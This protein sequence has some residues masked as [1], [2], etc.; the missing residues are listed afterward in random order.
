MALL[1]QPELEASVVH[2]Y[3]EDPDHILSW[4]AFR[5]TDSHGKI[6][7]G[8]M[9][10]PKNSCE[11]V[12]EWLT[13]FYS[14]EKEYTIE[15]SGA[16]QD[17]WYDLFFKFAPDVIIAMRQD[18]S[19]H[20]KRYYRFSKFSGGALL[21]ISKQE[22]SA[23]A[24]YLQKRAAVVFDLAYRRFSDLQ[25]TEAQARE[26]QIETALERVRSSSLA[27]H[28]S[29]ELKDVVK[30]VFENFRSLGLQNIDSV[31]IN[32]FHE[33]SRDFDLWLAAPGQDYTTNF[34][35][36][37]LDHPIANDFFNDVKKGETIHKG[38]YDHDL[39]NKYFEYMFENSDN[40][41]LPEERKK[42]ILNGRAY[43]VATGIAKHSSIFIHNYNGEKFSEETNGI[44]VRFSKV[45]DQAYTR[46]L[47]LQKAE[48][49]ARE[50]QI[51]TVLER[52]RSRTMA[53]QKSN[54]LTDVA[55]LL[56]EQVSALG[57]KTWTAGFNVWSEDN[58]SYVDYIT[59]PQG[60]F[61][62]PY[63][64]YTDTAEALTDISN[65]RK[66]GVEFDVQYVE[67][68]KIKQLYLALTKLDEKQ[69]EI[70]LQDGIRFPSHQYEHFVFGSKV[71]LMFIT[72]EPVP[73]AHDIFK[74]LGKVFEQTYTRFLDLQKAEANA[75]EA[76][77]EA[78]LERVRAKAMAMHSSKDLAET[79]SVFYRELKSLSV[80]PIRCGVALMDKESRMA[81]LTTM[82]T[83]GEGDSIEI[84]GKIKMAGHPVLDGVFESWLV[85]KEYHAVLRG[86]Q[87]KEYYQVLKPQIDYLDYSHDE[88]QFGYYFMFKEGDVYAWTEKE[89]T[90]DEL[91]IYR[92]FTTVISLTYKRYKD[93]Q[94]AEA[95]AREAKI[96]AGLER[97]RAR[98]M[99]MHSSEDVGAATAT[100]FTE[101]EKLGIQNLRGGITVI[102]A[103]DKQEVWGVTNLP[104]GRIIRS[105]GEFDMHLHALWRELLKAKLNNGDYNYYRLAGKDKEDY[106][107]ILNATPNYLSQPIK[108]FPDVHVQSYFF[109]EG[110]IWTNSLQPHSE[111][112]K[113]VMK[114]FAS[115]F[116]LT[117]RRYQDLQKA[118]AQAREAT[119]EACI[120]KSSW[121]SNGYAQFKRSCLYDRDYSI[122]NWRV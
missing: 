59:S 94:Q 114:R 33:G 27:M 61:I 105:I 35:L 31:N 90:E 1:G 100:M 112:D 87:I 70:M 117:F 16:K 12:R 54:E 58:N 63:T 103:G 88:A 119:I 50:A 73:E 38:I 23:E 49:Q 19:I 57:I 30:I 69:Y 39:K 43:S 74:R 5:P 36:P 26:A 13:K 86:N 8:H 48:A 102:K 66:S 98:T 111:E 92:R 76:Q 95:Q 3:E 118:E 72:Y 46:F 75:R 113:Q 108:D 45:F 47:D 51:E 91:T 99:A 62:E 34:R 56:F 37:Y 29:E 97:V 101:L 44:L 68:E 2:L 11:F 110:A 64:V 85:Q 14:E 115:V 53:M 107:N 96:E 10:L 20:D 106:I 6:A 67:G 109:G 24:T 15:L 4:R 120:G 65:A 18:N 52:V 40:K 104:D 81:E 41:H 32:I 80:V 21:M 121:Q 82:N 60:G 17:E 93:L 89:L 79:L 42:L 122:M 84:I 28:K 7:Y 9:S 83:T 78:G 55:S 77:I 22:P 71:S 25:K 116:S